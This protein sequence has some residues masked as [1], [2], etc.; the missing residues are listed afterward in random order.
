MRR[1]AAL[2]V[3][4]FAVYAA[5]LGIPAFD[6]AEYGGDEPHHLLTAES[7]VSD[8]DLDL[9]DE[10]ATRAYEDW[11]PRTLERHGRLTDGQANEPHGLGLA[12]LVTPAYAAGGPKLVQLQ[13]A[14]IAALAFVLAAALAR[15]IVPD[16]W[17]TAAAAVCGLS[18]PALAYSTAVLPE[19]AAAAALAGAAVLALRARELPRIRWVTGAAVLLGAL[20]WL[21]TTFVPAGL[22]VT[23]ALL[24]W[25]RRSARG[26]AAFVVA[27]VVIFSAVVYITVNDQLYGGVT[28]AGAQLPGERGTDAD[29]VAGYLDRAPRLAGLWLDRTYGALRWAPFVALAFYAAY[30]L[31]RSHREHLTRVLPERRE[32][33][34]AAALCLLACAAQVFT[35]ALLTKT[36]FG[37]WFPGL[38]LVAVL[39]LAAALCAWGL[40]HAPRVGAALGALTLVGS[41]W[42]YLELRIGGDG[43]IGP[44][45]A[46]PLGPLDAGLPL[47]ATGSAGAHVAAGTL[48][49]AL[50][51][52]V[53]REWRATRT[54]QT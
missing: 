7:L 19:M 53:A 10:Y 12:L 11:Y 18:P 25:L 16:P 30:L 14:A 2:W 15:R 48:A 13:M 17:A 32:V 27:E 42:L 52:V 54:A 46:A 41:V 3:A 37:F 1:A 22:M 50:A 9:R 8:A 4:L 38:H 43:W 28:P 49:A 23:L 35:A 45:S 5:T 20:P 51:L 44:T 31:W 26:F 24:H 6:G 29:F 36:M 33:E 34:A 39:P 40:R 47:F 21:G